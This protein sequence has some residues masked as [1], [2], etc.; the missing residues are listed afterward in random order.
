MGL[1]VSLDIIKPGYVPRGE[2]IIKL[3]VHPIK[4]I[5]PLQLLEQGKVEKI[6]GI[7]LSS[8]LKERK[9]SDRMS[10][11]CNQF[12]KQENLLASINSIYDTTSAQRGASLTLYAQTDQGCILG[13]D[14]AGRLGRTSEE[15]GKRVAKMLLE[16]LHSKATV[17]RHTADQ[18]IMYAALARGETEYLVPQVS[19]HVETNLWIIEKILGAKWKVEDLKITISGI[20]FKK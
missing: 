12:L 10:Q 14:L 18:L 1:D 9:V 13:S 19:A 7:A 15:I 5:T 4:E 3:K 6:E 20:A 2:G 8:H 16:D 11:T 17:D